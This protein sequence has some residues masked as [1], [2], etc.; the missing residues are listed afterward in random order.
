MAKAR[1]LALMGSGEIAPKLVKTHRE[2]IT[3]FHNPKIVLIATPYRFQ[4]NVKE[5]S[6]KIIDFFRV[7]LLSEV[8]PVDL[9]DGKDDSY[10]YV[11]PELDDDLKYNK[12]LKEADI[13]FSGPGSPSYALYRWQKSLT[14]DL[15]TEKLLNG[16]AVVFSS[17][18][19]LT[20]GA[21]SVPV[22]EIYKAGEAPKW[23]KGL[24][25]L[26]AIGIRAALIPHYNNAEG[27]TH[28]T[29]FC[30]LGERRLAFLEDQ[31]PRDTVIL[32]IDEHTCLSVDLDE[33]AVKVSGLG[34]VTVRYR[35]ESRIINTGTTLKLD[36]LREIISSLMPDG[37]EDPFSRKVFS[38]RQHQET[39]EFEQTGLHDNGVN[40]DNRGADTELREVFLGFEEEFVHSL[41]EKDADKIFSVLSEALNFL[42]SAFLAADPL[43]EESIK[44]ALNKLKSRFLLLLRELV[45]CAKNG[46]VDKKILYAPLVNGLIA[47]RNE[48]RDANLY[49]EA[50]RL[51]DILLSAGIQIQDTADITTWNFKD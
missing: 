51:R 19:V 5:L 26:E 27:G 13:V 16:G 41:N 14:K 28:D 45:S 9:P 17:A 47:M 24:N 10:S 40:A 33:S 3:K 6:E 1:I 35:G 50:D 42:M 2:I 23:L 15:L 21:Y 12:L 7:S 49:H 48:A 44:F 32:G 37:K 22:Y 11:L 25:I 20:L 34:N 36:G 29:R 8:I 30:Y 43:A 18:A 38:G 4:E 46:F 39:T 31:L